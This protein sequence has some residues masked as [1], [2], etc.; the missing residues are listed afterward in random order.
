MSL[1]N[2]QNLDHSNY[3]NKI[4]DLVNTPLCGFNLIE[5]SAGTGKTYNITKIVIRLILEKQIPISEILVVTFTNAAT[6]E[7][8]NRIINELYETK[9]IISQ[10]IS[11][12]NPWN[13]YLINLSKQ[14]SSEQLLKLIKKSINDFQ[15]ANIF[16]IHSFCNK[17]LKLYAFEASSAFNLEIV[18]STN[19][20]IT[21]FYN[22]FIRKYLL[23]IDEKAF[24]FINEF[25]HLKS[26]QKLIGID[27][28]VT[29]LGSHSKKIENLVEDLNRKIIRMKQI[30][31]ML[32]HKGRS[33]KG[34]YKEILDIAKTT[35]K[36]IDE[37]EIKKIKRKLDI[38]FEGSFTIKFSQVSPDLYGEMFIL[39][40]H[41]RDEIIPSIK[42]SLYKFIH[43]KIEQE[44]SVNSKITFDEMIKK[45]NQAVRSN[46][47][48]VKILQK[49]YKAVL[50]DEFQ[51]TDKL[52]YE[53][54]NKLFFSNKN[55]ISFIIGDPK[56]SIY[57]FRGA[58]IYSYINAKNQ[59]NNIY[60]LNTNYRSDKNFIDAINNFYKID[61]PFIN[62]DIHYQTIYAPENSTYQIRIDDNIKKPLILLISP[63]EQKNERK[64]HYYKYLI[65]EIV[66]YNNAI[67]DKKAFYN[68]KPLKL[69][70]IAILV[71]TNNE[72]N[73]IQKQLAKYN[74]KA[75]INSQSTIF[76]S[77][78]A[79]NLI[80]ILNAILYNQNINKIKVALLSN[81]FSYDA[82]FINNLEDNPEFLED[83]IL[84]FRNLY[85][86]WD[87]KGFI[88]MF[89]LF[90]K[91]FNIFEN[92]PSDCNKERIVTNILHLKEILH[93]IEKE[94]QFN[95]YD[96]VDYLERR[97]NS[98]DIF[99]NDQDEYLI[100]LES[101]DEAIG[102]YTIH[103]CKG[104][105]FP[106][107]FI[108]TEL[109]ITRGKTSMIFHRKNEIT[110]Q[111]E[112]IVNLV[113]EASQEIQLEDFEEQMRLLYV[114]LTRTKAVCYLFSP[115][116]SDSE[117]QNI[118]NNTENIVRSIQLIAQKYFIAKHFITNFKYFDDNIEKINLLDYYQES[119]NKPVSDIIERQVHLELKEPAKFTRQIGTY[120]KILSYSS[121]KHTSSSSN[122][123][124]IYD[125][126]FYKKID[127]D[128]LP[129]G[130][131]TGL[132]VHKIFEDLFTY[133][134]DKVDLII[135][136]AMK[137]YL[138][139]QKY[140]EQTKTIIYNTLSSQLD[141]SN[142]LIL[143]NVNIDFSIPEM[144]FNFPLNF[145]KKIEKLRNISDYKNNLFIKNISNI[146]PNKIFGYMTGIIDLFFFYDNKYYIIDWKTNYLDNYSYDN[147]LVEMLNNHYILQYYIYTLAI[148]RHLQNTVDN[149]NYE[150]DFGGVYYLFVRGIDANS[151]NGIFYDKPDKNIIS[152][153][154]EN[155]DVL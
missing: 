49:K 140:Y 69:T 116:L 26:I 152:F 126:D 65:D 61:R 93:K 74:I 121:I 119:L 90:Q 149:Y 125:Y 151:K 72:A 29:F 18:K 42:Y 35:I 55:C 83:I 150:K 128:I 101:E 14:N 64:A 97:V 114:A 15:N 122:I 147:I 132:Y 52:Q 1:K 19:N 145:I 47:L 12:D 17:I 113:D 67:I 80:Y 144:E 8:Q 96:L 73:I 131:I 77:D 134:F 127:D 34:A 89:E 48:F 75:I 71:S 9:N 120:R 3:N 30:Y 32:P 133:G 20:L 23:N 99:E 94:N 129:P 155:R 84:K 87:R 4:F 27:S 76:E 41:I 60:T 7:L 16:T 37:D 38:I 130:N 102:I 5:A 106:I 6:F 100:R 66:R 56:Q 58:D 115:L 123:F 24:K 111:Y 28:N 117:K 110:S 2:L 95:P 78:E 85:D 11:S 21:K 107:V 54:F 148:D 153:L 103:R 105:E 109:E 108:P 53:I 44:L 63:N 104:L 62:P 45:V 86:V 46:D 10:Q 92:L 139:D 57:K 135:Q 13:T 124:D 25:I 40:A 136:N 59:A 146:E 36:E 68:N 31:N 138:I 112:T 82:D 88:V 141:D 91:E 43:E 33:D 154:N 142:N 51:D 137:D 50:I 143:K 118:T 79:F 22:D 98:P 81:Y 39:Y 70:D